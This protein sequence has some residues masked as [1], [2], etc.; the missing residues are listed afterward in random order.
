MENKNKPQDRKFSLEWN[1]VQFCL[2]G[3]PYAMKL[4]LYVVAFL[5]RTNTI[6]LSQ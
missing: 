3:T 4:C 2:R 1:V 5:T 6:L